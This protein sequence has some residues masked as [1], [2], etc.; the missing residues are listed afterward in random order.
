M[1]GNL[2]RGLVAVSLLMACG[3]VRTVPLEETSSG[4]GSSGAPG[5]GS[6][7]SNPMSSSGGGD[8]SA[9]GDEDDGGEA[10][11]STGGFVPDAG[12]DPGLMHC[13][14]NA[15]ENDCPE[16]EKCMRV[17]DPINGDLNACFPIHENPQP[18]YAPCQYFDDPY[19]GHDNCGE[20]AFCR[21]DSGFETGICV[22]ICRGF[23]SA[24]DSCEDA[25]T[26][27]SVDCQSCY[28]SC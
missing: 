27:P 19:N 2:A 15:P 9:G 7:T 1:V 12:S 14:I 22:G 5:D 8:G 6:S 17:Y 24:E 23:G 11:S 26:I 16:G 25:E 20:Y 3:P 10:S 28:C 4:E 21:L 13:D 18:L